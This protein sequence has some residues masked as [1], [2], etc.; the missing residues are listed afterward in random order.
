MKKHRMKLSNSH[1]IKTK[2]QL[3]III[4]GS[5]TKKKRNFEAYTAT[6]SGI[7]APVDELYSK[8]QKKSSFPTA[9]SLV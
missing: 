9:S 7:K 4:T 1:L 2:N 8:R 6:L 3:L 5:I